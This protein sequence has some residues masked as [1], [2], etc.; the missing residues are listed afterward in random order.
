[1][2][3]FQSQCEVPLINPSENQETFIKRI[4]N[5]EELITNLSDSV[6]GDSVTGLRTKLQNQVHLELEAAEANHVKF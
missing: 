4:T 2:S 6:N 3:V 1:M 5:S